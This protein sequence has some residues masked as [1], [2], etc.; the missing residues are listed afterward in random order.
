MNHLKKSKKPLFVFSLL[1]LAAIFPN[2][3]CGTLNAEPVTREY[4]MKARF[5][6]NLLDFT[7]WPNQTFTKEK[8]SKFNLCILGKN[9]FGSLFDDARKEGLFNKHIVLK[10]N[11]PDTEMNNCNILYLTGSSI[12][13]L[14]R[15]L[16]NLKGKPVLIIGES[17]GF[18]KLGV[19][20]NFIEREN[21]IK[22][23]INRL[24]LSLQGIQISSFLLNIA[25]LVGGDPPVMVSVGPQE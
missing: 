3:F 19:G 4:S 18:G 24:A 22:L 20:V 9:K 21:R 25:L 10:H 23:E 6:V 16:K 17:E 5:I 15:A 7:Y 14:K 11:V 12:S 13:N 2:Q 8:E 1:F